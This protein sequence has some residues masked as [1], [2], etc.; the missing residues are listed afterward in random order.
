MIR[1]ILAAAAVIVVAIFGGIM[2]AIIF[3]IFLLFMALIGFWGLA[4][5]FG[6][7]VTVN[8]STKFKVGGEVIEHKEVRKYRWFTRIA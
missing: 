1:F 3:A 5:M 8:Y 4:W 2:F 6:V 7:P